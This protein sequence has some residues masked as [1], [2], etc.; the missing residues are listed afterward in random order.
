MITDDEDDVPLDHSDLVDKL[1]SF[2]PSSNEENFVLGHL[3][4]QAAGVIQAMDEEA[5][6]ISEAKEGAGFHDKTA[7][8]CIDWLDKDWGRL[9]RENRQLRESTVLRYIAKAPHLYEECERV[10]ICGLDETKAF[11]FSE[12]TASDEGDESD[13]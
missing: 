12:Y 3:L 13:D 4:F 7:V 11:L 10:C 5:A 1:R 6:K 2:S 9:S 8:E